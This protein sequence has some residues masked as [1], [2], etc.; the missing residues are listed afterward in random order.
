MSYLDN[1]SQGFQQSYSQVYRKPKYTRVGQTNVFSPRRISLNNLYGDQPVSYAMPTAPSLP[2]Y[3]MERPAGAV[4]QPQTGIDVQDYLGGAG[5]EKVTDPL[6]RQEIY[7]PPVVEGDTYQDF[8][9]N[10]YY[11]YNGEWVKLDYDT[12]TGEYALPGEIEKEIYAPYYDTLERADEI[13]RKVEN[14]RRSEERA[15]ENDMTW[16]VPWIKLTPEEQE[17]MGYNRDRVPLVESVRNWLE[18]YA[19]GL[20]TDLEKPEI[21]L[22]TDVLSWQQNMEDIVTQLSQGDLDIEDLAGSD[23]PM[24]GWVQGLVEE[25]YKTG[26][27]MGD[28][29][30]EE[31]N[32][33]PELQDMMDFYENNPTYA[34]NWRQWQRALASNALASGRTL[35]SGYYSDIVANAVS[36]TAAQTTDAV[37][38]RMMTEIGEQYD[39]ITDSMANMLREMGMQTDAELFS[40]Q[41]RLAKESIEQDYEMG[42]QELAQAIA[43]ANAARAGNIFTGIFGGILNGVLLA[44]L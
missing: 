22:E 29:F 39:Y 16:A 8:A 15:R 40:E 31:G 23:N 2:T 12:E 27:V 17:A 41:M 4:T 6:T 43:E 30:D 14:S 7:Q 42:L 24:A 10:R 26:R 1:L 20:I 25:S 18:E 36:Q 38:Q 13:L 11:G 19:K 3:A 34:E 33:A 28:F 37:M 35:N 21:E 44:L 9:G 32:L 5:Y